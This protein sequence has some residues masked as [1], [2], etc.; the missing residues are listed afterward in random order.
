MAG[1][2]SE[3]DV[4]AEYLGQNPQLAQWVD[5]CRSYCESNK[6]WV[7]RREFILRNMEAFPTVEP[8]VPSSSLDRL[9]SLSMVWANHVF[10]GCSY[11][12]AVMDKIKEMG[13]GIVVP[14]AP[15]YKTTKDEILARGKRS[16]T[17]E[18]DADSCVK[19]AKSGPNELAG[20]TSTWSVSQKSGP[21][22]Q[23]P[24]EH[25]PFFNRLYKA[26]AWKLVSAGG[27][28]PNL[29]HF[30][31][32]RSCAESCKE[33]LACVFVPLK[34]ITGLPAGRTQKEG[35][36]CEIRCQTVYMGTGYGRDESAAKAMASKEALKVFQ[37][38][39][40]TVKICRRRYKGKDVEDLVLLD[41]QPR[42]QGFPPALSYPFQ[43]EQL[44]DGSSDNL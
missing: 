38:R 1:E 39:K 44:E 8:G 36:V 28:G 22:P 7:A 4:V 25:Q 35:H 26:V 3:E 37:G 19:R 10:L 13:D 15:V 14:D 18:G 5:T 17:A 34:D 2:K 11:P 20:R 29:D 41:E 32:L 30:E 40:V 42:S 6:Q 23:A 33:T 21:L 27:F 43:D 16:A 9:L 24:A 12:Q 31:I